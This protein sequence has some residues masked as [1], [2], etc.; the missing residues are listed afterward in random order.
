MPQPYPPN[1]VRLAYF[2]QF[3]DAN[4]IPLARWM[5]SVRV[6]TTANGTLATAYNAGDTVDG[7]VLNAG[8]RILLKDQTDPSENGIYIVATSATGAP[9]R[10]LDMPL[11]SDTAGALVLVELGTVNEGTLWRS[12]GQHS[13]P[14]GTDLTWVQF[15]GSGGAS[16]SFAFFMGG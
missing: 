10:S 11:D 5:A 3:L 7:Q 13:H 4:G 2:A 6:A 16:R 8:D 15:S 1:P 14:A 12:A 9:T